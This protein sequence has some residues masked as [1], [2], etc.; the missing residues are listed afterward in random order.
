MRVEPQILQRLF[1]TRD[2]TSQ[3]A[4]SFGERSIKQRDTVFDAKLLG[5]SATMFAACQH[6]VSFINKH[7]RPVRL[8]HSNYLLKIAKIA[9]HRVNALDNHQLA[10][11]FV[12]APP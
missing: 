5:C 2:E 3:C 6:R 11:A 1:R 8:R 4:K 12:P 10:S 9:V 7:A